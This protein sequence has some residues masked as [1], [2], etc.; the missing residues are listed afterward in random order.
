MLLAAILALGLATPSAGAADISPRC[1]A[2]VATQ[3]EDEVR[4]LD[5]HTSAGDQS[6][7]RFDELDRLRSD[8]VQEMQIIDSTCGS[9]A[10]AA[11]I[12]SQIR[13][14]QAWVAALQSD[15]IGYRYATTCPAAHDAVVS[16]LLATGWLALAKATPS[17]EPM[18]PL[19]TEVGAKI[20]ARAATVH[21]TLPATA[22]TS[23]YWVRGIQERARQQNATCPE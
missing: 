1:N 17:Q 10:T 18:P 20:E 19:V 7:A 23:D 11:G 6:R 4:M 3:I 13:A 14:T 15:F 8:L 2:R 12:D 22:D 21:L 16:G 5:R 9:D